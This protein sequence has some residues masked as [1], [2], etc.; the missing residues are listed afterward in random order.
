MD[1]PGPLCTSPPNGLDFPSSSS[2][3]PHPLSPQA[4]VYIILSAQKH[5]PQPAS[6]PLPPASFLPLST[7][8]YPESQFKYHWATS[9]NDPPFP[10]QPGHLL[11]LAFIGP[12]FLLQSPFRAGRYLLEWVNGH[13]HFPSAYHFIP[14]IIYHS[15]QTQGR[16]C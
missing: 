4:S 8:G 12:R 1:W 16:L 14:V 10:S 6:L 3:A 7:L 9:S 13:S 11:N 2:N 5:P 15:Q